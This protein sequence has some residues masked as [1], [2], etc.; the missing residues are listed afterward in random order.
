MIRIKSI[1]IEPSPIV[2]GNI[3]DEFTFALVVSPT[4]SS[5]SSKV[6]ELFTRTL[7]NPAGISQEIKN[8]DWIPPE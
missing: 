3:S 8:F 5:D 6:E 7:I 4:E 1:E 2:S